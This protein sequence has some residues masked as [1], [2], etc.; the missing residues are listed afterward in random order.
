GF[1]GLLPHGG[2]CRF[3]D[4]A[5]G[6]SVDVLRREELVCIGDIPA[7]GLSHGGQDIRST[8]S[9]GKSLKRDGT[10]RP[11]APSPCRRRARSFIHTARRGSGF[12]AVMKCCADEVP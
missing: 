3:E 9:V 10:G 2:E 1:V 6:Q 12:S 4:L 8:A 5:T 11:S 7:P